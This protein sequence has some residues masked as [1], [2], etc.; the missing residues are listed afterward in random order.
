MAGIPKLDLS[1]VESICK[2]LGDTEKGFTGT[3]IAKLLNESGIE[4]IDATNTKWKRLNS[5]LVNK[6]KIDGCANN[7]LA[8]IQN[9]LSPVRHFDSLEWFNDTQYK[10]N[11]IL[12]FSGLHLGENGKIS[13]VAKSSTIS[14]AAARASRLKDN[15]VIR[16]V[17][18]DVLRY[19]KEELVVDNYFHAVFEA[20]KSVA[21]K[22]RNKTGLTSDEQH[23]S[24]KRFLLN[25]FHI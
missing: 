20:T 19:C 25:Q 15:L 24:M 23:W 2:V 4:D 10:I 12:S 13:A 8:F 5:A 3:E 14:E 9:S 7:L 6:Q 17:H 22:I 11:Q 1:V 16:K 18:L 21:Q